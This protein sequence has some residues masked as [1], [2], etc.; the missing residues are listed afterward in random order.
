MGTVSVDTPQPIGDSGLFIKFSNQLHQA[1]WVID[2]PNKR[3]PQYL[4]NFNAY[5]SAQTTR[6]QAIANA[7]ALLN[8]ANSTLLQKQA[9]ARPEDVAAA[10]GAVKVAEGAYANDFIYA[11]AD[12]V[13][14]A[15]N[16]STGEIALT[17]Q[18]IIS[19]I[20]KTSK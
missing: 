3:A 6:D 16:I 20:V 17:N 5:Q 8:Q 7:T 13:M 2:I 18:K 19:M 4:A 15:T 12:G 9:T 11:P 14:T 1:N 10:E